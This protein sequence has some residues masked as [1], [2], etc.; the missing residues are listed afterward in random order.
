MTRKQ[1]QDGEQPRK[2][3]KRNGAHF[4]P[5]WEHTR[6]FAAP[7][8]QKSSLPV[9][10]EDGKVTRVN[11]SKPS[12]VARAQKKSASGQKHGPPIRS[13]HQGTPNATSADASSAVPGKKGGD[14]HLKRVRNDLESFSRKL[15]SLEVFKERVASMASKVIA[16]PEENIALLRELRRMARLEKGRKAALVILTESQL[17]KDICPSYRIRGIT[18]K[19]AETKVSKEV[20]KL[21]NYEQ[22]LSTAHRAFIGA[23]IGLSKWSSGVGRETPAT[24][25]MHH[26]RMASCKA[27]AELMRALPHFNEASTVANRVCLLLADREIEV[28]KQS[29]KALKAVMGD[30]HRASGATLEVCVLIAKQLASVAV[31]K[32]HAVPAEVVEPLAEIQFGR[33]PLLPQSKKAANHPK[34]GKNFNRKKRNRQEKEVEGIEETEV[35]KDMRE[36]NAGASSS[37]LFQAKKSLLKSVCDAYFNIIK[38]ASS[39]V[40]RSGKPRVPTPGGRARK[41][42]PALSPALKGLLRVASFISTEVI[43]A[44]LGALTP[45]LEAGRLPLTVRFRCLAAAYAILG[46]HSRIQQADPDSFTGDTRA[47]DTS[48][49]AALG[50]LYGKDTR[51]KEDEYLTFDAVESLLSCINFREVPLVR[52]ASIAR[53]LSI[54]AAACAPTHTCSIGLLRVAQVLMPSMLVS[55]IYPRIGDSADENGLK[56]GIA[57]IQ[58]FDA[59]TNDPEITGADKSAAWEL[60]PLMSHFHPT[61]R[62]IAS[63]C[64]GGKCGARLPKSPDDILAFTKGHS[65]A[66]GGFNPPPQTTLQTGNVRNLKSRRSSIAESAVLRAVFEPQECAEFLYGKD[67]NHSEFFAS[68]WAVKQDSESE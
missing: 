1:Q 2:K 13:D 67:E 7:K 34:K 11:V 46:V 9:V 10:Q 29:V 30:A 55:S 61:V 5:T 35:E 68:A 17:Y 50:C 52:S 28:R 8:R 42:P 60:S 12:F 26:V 33:F 22:A 54:M 23:C 39:T 44:I 64:A 21:R 41:P 18:D 31:G 15:E 38:A 32:S 16:S 62:I 57:D 37:E 47:M 66:L 3:A 51:S 45:L 19:E 14:N 59:A 36:A 49:Y 4:I 58:S 40:E 56:A 48:L 24:R 63:E 65:S 43:E 20:A 6:A 27:L 25:D 53:R